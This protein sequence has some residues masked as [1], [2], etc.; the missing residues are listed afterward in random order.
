MELWRCA[1]PHDPG[2]T[3][4]PLDA[5][6]AARLRLDKLLRLRE[7]QLRRRATVSRRLRRPYIDG[8]QLERRRSRSARSRRQNSSIPR[9]R[10]PSPTLTSLLLVHLPLPRL[11]PLLPQ[12]RLPQPHSPLLRLAKQADNV[13][14]S[15]RRSSVCRSRTT[16]AAFRLLRRLCPPAQTSPSLSSYHVILTSL[17]SAHTHG[18]TTTHR[19]P[20]A[21]PN[22]A[23]RRLSNLRQKPALHV[24]RTHLASVSSSRPT[25]TGPRSGPPLPTCRSSR[26]RTSSPTGTSASFAATAT[27]NTSTPSPSPR[28]Y[29]DALSRPCSS[30]R[31]LST[32]T[33]ATG[34]GCSRTLI[35]ATTWM[36]RTS[37]GRRRG[38][39]SSSGA[40]VSRAGGRRGK[41]GLRTRTTR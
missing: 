7:V 9:P 4:S 37:D 22:P 31:G 15:S 29:P 17:S 14:G 27:P 10:R 23:R 40:R 34:R 1:P 6:Q 16:D 24:S 5:V 36:P 32:P 18:T 30:S 33:T 26:A 2:T 35:V 3:S 28:F 20:Q 25:C 11:L 13:A 38:G 39:R 19:A 12:R 8:H 21:P 41:V